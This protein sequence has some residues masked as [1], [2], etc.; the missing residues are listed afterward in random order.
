M[1][2]HHVALATKDTAATHAFYTEVMGFDLVKVVAAATPGDHGGWS[3]HFFYDTGSDGLMAFWEL[4]DP[5]IGEDYS[6]GLSKPL[7]LPP[8]V[9]HLAFD[10]PTLADLERHRERWREH[11]ITVAQVDHGFCISIYAT[12]PNGIMVEFCHTTRPFGA[13]EI[14]RANEYLHSPNPPLDGDYPVTIYEPVAAPVIA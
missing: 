4:H 14:A 6:A 9:N 12:D 1:G 7:G 3:K 2:F 8:W 10:A 5:K 11:G 13:D